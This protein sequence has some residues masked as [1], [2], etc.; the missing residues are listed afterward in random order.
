[1]RRL[2]LSIWHPHLFLM[3]L[4][5]LEL[6]KRLDSPPP[7][8]PQPPQPHALQNSGNLHHLV[9]SFRVPNLPPPPSVFVHFSKEV[10]T[11]SVSLSV[12]VHAKKLQRPCE[13]EAIGCLSCIAT[14]Y[15]LPEWWLPQC[16]SL[17][18]S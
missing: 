3:L 8:P 18:P 13:V 14:S 1:M 9:L 11:V 12:R 16:V 5:H 15:W 7:L 17:W 6:A 2:A 10:G 4:A